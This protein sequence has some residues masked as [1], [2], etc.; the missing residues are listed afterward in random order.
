MPTCISNRESILDINLTL[1]GVMQT[2][3][4][5]FF[6]YVWSDLAA[7][8]ELLASRLEGG[9]AVAP[10]TA[11]GKKRKRTEGAGKEPGEGA[12]SEDVEELA[13]GLLCSVQGCFMYDEGGF[14]TAARFEVVMPRVLALVRALRPLPVYRALCEE[15]LVPTIAQM[16]CA[17]GKDVLWK[18]LNHQLL[19]QTRDGDWEVR[20][21]ALK[22]LHEC[23]VTVGEEY[24]SMLPE[25]I[26]FLAELLEDERP[27]VEALCKTAVQHVEDLSGE[28]LDSY[29]S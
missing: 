26:S 24:L 11:K 2:I 8:L 14:L 20:Y 5:P 6:G 4:V 15:L 22:A 25:S 18:P 17:A 27:E 7:D 21:V 12:R 10:A 29:L 13:R 23:F 9:G 19:M 1:D 16:A 28:S 3:F